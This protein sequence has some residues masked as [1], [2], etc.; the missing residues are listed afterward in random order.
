VNNATVTFQL[1]HEDS[2]D[3]DDTTR[4]ENELGHS[5]DLYI[6]SIWSCIL[7]SPALS[8]YLRGRLSGLSRPKIMSTCMVPRWYILWFSAS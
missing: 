1:D 5:L 8:A 3:N 4:L 2:H 6:G 7:R